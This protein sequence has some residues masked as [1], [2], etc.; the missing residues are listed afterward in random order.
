M[1]HKTH[2]LIILLDSISE[3]VVEVCHLY[4]GYGGLAPLVAEAASGSVEG[5]LQV[6]DGKHPEDYRSLAQSVDLCHP[7]RC[8]HADIVEV[9][10]VAAYHTADYYDGIVGAGIDGEGGGVDQFYCAGYFIGVDICGFYPGLAQGVDGAVAQGV[11]HIGIPVGGEYREAGI[12][13]LRNG[14]L[15]GLPVGIQYS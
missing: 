4:G 5:L 3:A 12:L 15:S 8:L 9:G 11:G 2:A 14:K 13:F 1:G 6:V 10:G 7:Y